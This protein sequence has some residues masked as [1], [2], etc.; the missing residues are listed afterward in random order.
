[1]EDS[2]A[3][4]VRHGV[5][6]RLGEIET[7]DDVASLYGFRSAHG[8]LALLGSLSAERRGE[9]DRRRLTLVAGG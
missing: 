4:A 9:I 1:V 8:R 2:L 7:E 5:I 3:T 6:E